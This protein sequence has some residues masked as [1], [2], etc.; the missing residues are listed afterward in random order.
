MIIYSNTEGEITQWHLDSLNVEQS[1]TS[2]KDNLEG[3][4][5][6]DVLVKKIGS[7]SQHGLTHL[8]VQEMRKKF[9]T[10]EFPE[11][12]MNSFLQLFFESF[13]DAIIIILMCASA[14]SLGVGIWEDPRTGW[15]E[16]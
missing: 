11:S 2:N 6:I 3:L 14:V 12:P 16:G 9:G 10:N 5:G 7:H 15:I 1:R 13:E 8:Q 4:G